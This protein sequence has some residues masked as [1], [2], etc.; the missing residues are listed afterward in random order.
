MGFSNGHLLL[1]IGNHLAL[2]SQLLDGVY[3]SLV[4]DLPLSFLDVVQVKGWCWGGE[5]W[6]R[7]VGDGRKWSERR[8]G[9]QGT[10]VGQ[11]SRHGSCRHTCHSSTHSDVGHTGHSWNIW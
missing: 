2:L 11:R 1:A 7:L 6:G 5:A 3:I 9:S 4:S 10:H 8:H